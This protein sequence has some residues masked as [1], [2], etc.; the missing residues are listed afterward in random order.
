[1]AMKTY[2]R[3]S[4]CWGCAVIA[5][6]CCAPSAHAAWSTE[7]VTV[8]PTTAPIPLVE[9]CADGAYGTFA[10][11][12]EG[13]PSGILR[14][15]HLL[16]T[17][18]LDPAWPAGA[19][20]CGVSAARS[21][22]VAL[23]DRLGGVYLSWKEG[24]G[25]YV[26]RLDPGAAVAAGWPARGRFLGGVFAD[27]PRPSTIEDGEHGIYLAWGVATSTAVAIHLGPANTGAGG[28]P[29]SARSVSVG[30]LSNNTIY[31]PQIALAPDGGIFAAW[32]MSSTDEGAAP[33]AWRLRR[34][35]SAGLN[36]AGWPAEGVSFGSFQ[37]ELLGSPVKA[38]LLALSPDGRGGVFLTIGNPIGTEPG[39]GAILETRLYRLQGSG[40]SASDWPAEGKVATPAPPYYTE[41]GATPD[42]SYGIFDDTRDGALA[43]FPQFGIH[44]GS[45]VSF[46]RCDETGQF[47]SGV[48]ASASP[49][50]HE[51]AGS[52]SGGYFVASFYPTGPLGPYQPYAFLAVRNT[53]P[54][55]N[56]WTE[57]HWECCATYYGDIGLAATQDGGAVFFWSQVLERIGLFARRFN[58]AGEVTAVEPGSSPTVV[59]SRLRFVPG[60]GVRA[61]VELPGAD[62]ARLELFDLAGRRIASQA[63]E[64]GAEELTVE[65]TSALPSGLYIGRLVAGTQAIAGKLIIAR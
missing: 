50:G 3:G 57:Y 64:A 55:W 21:E 56:G 12:Q 61:T 7:P 31:W 2:T 54:G 44:N 17:G 38:S 8:T 13:S 25:L 59:L 45:N 1:M 48:A 34:L 43:G 24:S 23:P 18:D 20:A 39:W 47:D 19:V 29:N 5:L 9:G 33:S 11:W 53:N 22:L 16:A 27:S 6:A 62:G 30:D 52:G 65:G 15:Q 42:Y 14:V 26:T 36:A 49:V 63:I 40:E 32:A 28:W 37:R 4:F 58:P 10:A 51:V 41:F 60:V 46:V 35:T